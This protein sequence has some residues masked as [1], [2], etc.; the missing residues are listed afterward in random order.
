MGNLINRS[1]SA[2]GTRNIK[3]NTFD[4]QSRNERN[5]MENSFFIHA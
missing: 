1:M 2:M 5:N 4:T 3:N